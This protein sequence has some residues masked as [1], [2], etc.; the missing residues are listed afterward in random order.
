MRIDSV[1]LAHA[2][3]R[4]QSSI[5][6]TATVMSQPSGLSDAVDKTAA[7]T[8]IGAKKINSKGRKRKKKPLNWDGLG[9]NVDE[10]A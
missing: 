1:Q 4:S 2:L 3:A 7:K 10:W 5:R 6:P 8:L 9:A